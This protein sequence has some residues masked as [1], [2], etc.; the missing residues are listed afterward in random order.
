MK[1]A[2]NHL[3]RKRFGVFLPFSAKI[4]QSVGVCVYVYICMCMSI[5]IYLYVCMCMYVRLAF[6]V[7]E[8]LPHAEYRFSGKASGPISPHI[9]KLFVDFPPAGQTNCSSFFFVFL[10]LKFRSFLPQFV[11]GGVV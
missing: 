9:T 10:L 7:T 6:D 8:M 4:A 1:Q 5:C 11:N 2:R 3:F